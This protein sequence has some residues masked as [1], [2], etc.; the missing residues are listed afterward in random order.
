MYYYE[1]GIAKVNA[2]H[3][4]SYSEYSIQGIMVPETSLHYARA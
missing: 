1:E 3:V 4:Q 2:P